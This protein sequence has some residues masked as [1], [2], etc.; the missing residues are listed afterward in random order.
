[1]QRVFRRFHAC[2]IIGKYD[3]MI[4]KITLQ[5]AAKM[6]NVQQCTGM[7]KDGIWTFQ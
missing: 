6:L 5:S 2:E 1:M 7:F 3:H 4:C